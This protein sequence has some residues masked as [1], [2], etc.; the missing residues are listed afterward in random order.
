MIISTPKLSRYLLGQLNKPCEMFR[1]KTNVT[2]FSKKC[3]KTKKHQIFEDV[4]DN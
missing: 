4:D 1:P 3:I 2:E